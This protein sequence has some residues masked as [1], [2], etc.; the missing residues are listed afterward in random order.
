MKGPSLVDVTALRATTSPG[1]KVSVR[2]IVLV[3]V[4]GRDIMGT[5]PAGLTSARPTLQTS[6][7]ET[8]FQ[9]RQGPVVAPLCDF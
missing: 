1:H 3:S 8:V 7:T 5:A 4:F 9:D 6:D 2:M